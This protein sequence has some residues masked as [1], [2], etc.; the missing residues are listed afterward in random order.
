MRIKFLFI[1][2][3]S[4]ILSIHS[5]ADVLQVGRHV[6]DVRLQDKEKLLTLQ[7]QIKGKTLV[8]VFASW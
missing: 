8:H 6:P 1:L 5:K 7:S 2:A 3:S 4:L